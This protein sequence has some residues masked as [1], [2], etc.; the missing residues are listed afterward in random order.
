MYVCV[1]FYQLIHLVHTFKI[2]ISVL[3]AKSVLP[4]TAG[5]VAINTFQLWSQSHSDV[6]V[7]LN[8]FVAILSNFLNA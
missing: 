2:K 5:D 3:L 6:V 7:F 8:N 1:T 4:K